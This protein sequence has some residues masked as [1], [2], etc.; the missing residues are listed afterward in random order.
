MSNRRQM[1]AFGRGRGRNT[2]TLA[3]NEAAL[4]MLGEDQA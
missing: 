2:D 1:T 3:V 4:C